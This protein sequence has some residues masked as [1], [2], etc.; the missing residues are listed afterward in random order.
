MQGDAKTE[1]IMDKLKNPPVAV[2]LFQ[3]KYKGG[4]ISLKDFITFDHLLKETLP[5]RRDNIH[6]GL[7][8]ASTS[9]PLGKSQL[10]ATSDAKIE[11]YIYQ[12]VDQKTRLEL[13]DG[14]ITYVDEH[15]YEGWNSFKEHFFKYIQTLEE[16]LS[17]VL[18]NRLSL[19]FINKFTLPN[20][21]KPQEYFNI[22]VSSA[23]AINLPFPLSNYGFR[24]NMSI[25][26]SDIY[27]IVNQ[28]IEGIGEDKYLYTLDIDVLDNQN[29][30]FN[31]QTISNNID[32]LRS[33]KNRIFEDAITD[34]TKELCN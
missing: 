20:I 13:S 7:N 2:A 28:N 25:P 11:A 23:N 24:L 3:L 27:S 18:I 8:F 16:V 19:R 32:N 15:K 31:L 1:T 5:N 12:S 21:N 22:V 10:S 6:V 17:K 9:I 14:T 4:D 30:S 26:D 34:K 29:L 33:I